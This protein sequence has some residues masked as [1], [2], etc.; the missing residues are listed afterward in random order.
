MPLAEFRLAEEP[1]PNLVMPGAD[2]ECKP[3]AHAVMVAVEMDHAF[4][5]T[6]WA[7]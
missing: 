4:E 6:I 2:Y 1:N 3:T 5:P 7:D